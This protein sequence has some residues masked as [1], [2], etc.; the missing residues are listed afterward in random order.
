MLA[1]E[2]ERR[3]ESVTLPCRQS[4]SD[5]RVRT[6]TVLYTD[7]NIGSLQAGYAK[8]RYASR[9]GCLPC[10]GQNCKNVLFVINQPPGR[11]M[12]TAVTTYK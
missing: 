10:D 9:T 2:L 12:T 8:A 3:E 6:G 5:N 4:F 1:S 11:V 7:D